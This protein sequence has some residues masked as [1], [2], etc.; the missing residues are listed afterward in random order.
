M[1]R[2]NE[3]RRAETDVVDLAVLLYDEMA[4]QELDSDPRVES[5]GWMPDDDEPRAG[6][7]ASWQD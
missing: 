6:Q 1:R 3:I 5:R 4:K 2:K 7:Q